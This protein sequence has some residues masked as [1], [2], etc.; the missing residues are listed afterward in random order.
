MNDRRELHPPSLIRW[1]WEITRSPYVVWGGIPAAVI[2]AAWSQ[3][4]ETGY[5]WSSLWSGQFLLRLVINIVITGYGLG[6]MMRAVF[7]RAAAWLG[8]SLRNGW[9]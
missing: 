3:F 8:I 5:V 6:L 7:R 9:Q 4:G 1:F 2:T